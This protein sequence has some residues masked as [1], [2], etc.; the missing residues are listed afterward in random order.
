[1]EDRKSRKF[2][3]GIPF[4]FSL[5]NRDSVFYSLNIVFSNIE[6]EVPCLLLYNLCLIFDLTVDFVLLF[7]GCDI[8][9]WCALSS[10]IFYP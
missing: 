8:Y 1:M 4:L 5:L 9:N 10:L 3:I 7:Q 6:F 2:F